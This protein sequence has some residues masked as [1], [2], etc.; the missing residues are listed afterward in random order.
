MI[1]IVNSARGFEEADPFRANIPELAY[2]GSELKPV[3]KPYY[4]VEKMSRPGQIAY[5]IYESI[6]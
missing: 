3:P 5:V 6:F 2:F 4:T 1:N